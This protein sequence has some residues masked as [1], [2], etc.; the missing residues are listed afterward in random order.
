MTD[1]IFISYSGNRDER[2]ALWIAL[3]E[4]GLQPWRDV[5]D[6]DAAAEA[7]REIPAEIAQCAG[8]ILWLSENAFA[9]DFVANIEVPAVRDALRIREI[10]VL[11]VFDGLE[12]EEAESRAIQRWGLPIAAYNGHVLNRAES[13]ETEAAAIAERLVRTRL[14]TMA[15]RGE[16]P[17]VRGVT[18]DDVAEHRDVAT[19]NFDWRH[20]YAD[21]RI[22]DPEETLRLVTALGS[23][24]SHLKA[25]F[26][27]GPTDLALKTHLHVGIALGHALRRPTGFVPRMVKDGD[28]WVAHVVDLQERPSMEVRRE[29]G[30]ASATCA[31]VE[32]SIT[33]NVTQGVDQLITALGQRY[34][35]RIL[36]RP[37]AGPGQ[38]SLTDPITANIWARQVTEEMARLQTLTGVKEIDLFIASPIEFSVFLGW[39]LNAAGRVHIYHW[40][41]NT[42]PYQRV[43]TLPPV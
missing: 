22:P 4:H 13:P 11:P 30:S 25:A 24:M 27:P 42:G 20:A 32:V 12:P 43:W 28:V 14:R 7:Q 21:G 15:A 34:R 19:L 18:R 5:E 40:A 29:P 41:G 8:V 2:R 33:R 35:E 16:R 17:V 10:S 1:K 6:L 36:L 26:A 23:S 38:T 9:S 37:S 3:R 31:S 39:W